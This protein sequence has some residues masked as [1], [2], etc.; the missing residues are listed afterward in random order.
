MSGNGFSS[1]ESAP[2]SVADRCRRPAA[3]NSTAVPSAGGADG[4]VL[5]SLPRVL[6]VSRPSPLTAYSIGGADG[7]FRASSIGGADGVFRVS[8]IGGADGAFRVSSIG[9][10]DGAFR[11]FSV[12]G[13]DGTHRALSSSAVFDG[14]DPAA[15]RSGAAVSVGV[16]LA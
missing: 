4:A 12:G 14:G 6:R 15:K 2:S 13:A 11:A 16:T 9:S 7:T 8:S 3:T 10:A 1:S 5:S